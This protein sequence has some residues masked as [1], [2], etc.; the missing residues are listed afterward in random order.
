M[1]LNSNL[2]PRINLFDLAA[3]KDP[4]TLASANY[5]AFSSTSQIQK[6][7]TQKIHTR[8]WWIW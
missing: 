2:A 3:M 6:I 8:A 4:G 1:E 7:H 5:F